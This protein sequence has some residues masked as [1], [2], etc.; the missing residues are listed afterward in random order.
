MTVFGFLLDATMI[1]LLIVTIH[2]A[3]Q[4]KK[5]LTVLRNEGAEMQARLDGFT[6][7][8]GRA[9]QS[10]AALR[11]LPASAPQRP[12]AV[13]GPAQLE[14]AQAVRDE[15]AFLIEAGDR[16]AKH[17]KQLEKS[18]SRS[19]FD[20]AGPRPAGAST[21]RRAAGAGAPAPG[22]APA[23]NAEIRPHGP[24]DAKITPHPLMRAAASRESAAQ[25]DTAP[26]R[27]L[28]AMG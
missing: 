9:E 26:M 16:V 23:T 11:A 20:A 28:R 24:S 10:L 13:T 25:A 8:A 15:L 3:L 14:R 19:A 6:E 22:P 7:A 4:L 18:V 17:L 12:V 1:V 27:P 21:L 5:R 2:Y